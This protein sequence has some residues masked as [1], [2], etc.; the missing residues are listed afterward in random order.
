MAELA[1]DA[2][3]P[4]PSDT[5][6]A[7]FPQPGMGME[8]L[9]LLEERGGLLG[10]DSWMLAG[11]GASAPPPELR[12][13]ASSP[14]VHHLE[15]Q[16]WGS[17]PL[18]I[19]PTR[20]APAPGELLDLT[21]SSMESSQTLLAGAAAAAAPHALHAA[22]AQAHARGGSGSF[23]EESAWLAVRGGYA[24][25]APARYGSAPA[26]PCA[27]G[28]GFAPA[29]A[30]FAHAAQL[31]ARAR[32]LLPGDALAAAEL[33]YGAGGSGHGSAHLSAGGSAHA[34]A[35]F[36]GGGGSAH[37]GGY[38][39][40]HAAGGSAHGGAHFGGGGSAHG[41]GGYFAAAGGSAHGAGGSAHGAGGGYFAAA[42]AGGSAHGGAH[43][44]GSA[45]GAGY[46]AAHAGS[47]PAGGAFFGGAPAPAHGSFPGVSLAGGDRLLPPGARPAPGPRLV[48]VDQGP[49]ALPAP[50]ATFGADLDLRLL[51][52]LD[53]MEVADS[54]PQLGGGGGARG[55]GGGEYGRHVAGS[56]PLPALLE[57]SL[58]GDAAEGAGSESGGAAW[59]PPP[60][61]LPRRP[62]A[63]S[64]ATWG[65][66]RGAGAPRRGAAAP[67]AIARGGAHKAAAPPRMARSLSHSTAHAAAGLLASSLDERGG[68]LGERPVRS[69][70]RRALAV[71]AAALREADAGWGG[72][73]SEFALSDD[74]PGSS[75]TLR[76]GAASSR[77]AGAGASPG[78]AAGKKK[79]NPWSAEET[80]A[81]VEGVRAAG[82]GKW[83][84]IKRL[85]TGGV[86]A[87]LAGRSAVDL[88][89][90]WRNLARVA[91][92]PRAALRARLAQR[93]PGDG[94]PLE[95]MLA[96][97]DLV[98]A[99]G[100]GGGE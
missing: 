22:A 81:L 79:H 50:L 36:G 17:G 28:A 3:N 37:G 16:P 29:H 99:G 18:P 2:R 96:V 73:D 71:T 68:A 88:K 56:A 10:D 42:G 92:L 35:H 5:A 39:A 80:A 34:G 93:A 63:S 90:K 65:G 59:A 52:D 82:A 30:Q 9:F 40:A 24:A 27:C 12:R 89:D 86:A 6:L 20:R 25:G 47:A 57:D 7:P 14:A 84:E 95:L 75:D 54:L 49:L 70:A 11:A 1:S 61:E 26:Q 83:A 48:P 91:R 43:F 87:A 13:A 74:A 72:S 76:G 78:S 77:A 67:M 97:K 94:A 58:A 66:A 41:G 64:L 15:A 46:F 100:G 38:F 60:G 23:T 69:A 31:D 85:P 55:H 53:F 21:L 8:D 4:D 51:D 98:E 45:P 32:D 62:S 33:Q 44:G 19:R